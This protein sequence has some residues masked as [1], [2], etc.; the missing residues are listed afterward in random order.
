MTTSDAALQ[1][2]PVATE[3]IGRSIIGCAITAHRILGPGFKEII[4]ERAF[5]WSWM[6]AGSATNARRRSGSLPHVADSRS[7]D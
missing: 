5:V 3:R 6:P 2:I 7:H 1:P 4:Y